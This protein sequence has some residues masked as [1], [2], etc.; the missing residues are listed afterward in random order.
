WQYLFESLKPEVRFNFLFGLFQ[1]PSPRR[2]DWLE[3]A[4]PRTW[5][6][7][8]SRNP[9]RAFPVDGLALASPAQTKSTAMPEEQL[10]P[11]LKTSAPLGTGKATKEV[12]HMTK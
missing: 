4:K 7:F 12:A 1:G 2:L 3:L 11:T 6:N 5:R 8:R 9:L 10:S